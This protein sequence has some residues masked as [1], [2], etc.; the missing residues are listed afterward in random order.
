MAPE[1]VL[2]Q[3]V[4]GRADI[5]AQGAVLY[6]MLAGRRLFGRD[7]TLGT[8]DAVLT[9]EAP[10]LSDMNPAVPAALSDVMRR[11]LMK[12]AADRFADA[13]DLEYAVAAIIADRHPPRPITL[14]SIL[15]RPAP[16]AAAII[17]LAAC[18]LGVWQW[19]Q[20]N[21]RHQWARTVAVP[22]AQRLFDH[23]N[24]AEAFLLAR[25]A[26]AILPDDPQTQQLWLSVSVPQ[27]VVSEPAGADA[28]IAAYGTSTEWHSLGRTPLTGV[29][30][31]R[32]E[33]RMR[34]VKAG[35]EAI[36]VARS[37][38]GLTYRL[39]LP[40]AV[41]PG[42]VRVAGGRDPRRFGHAGDVGEFWIDRFEVTNRQFKTFVDG[43]G[44][45]RRDAGGSRSST[46]MTSGGR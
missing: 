34:L 27:S 13:A 15:S 7:S 21:A 32:G 30:L 11:C 39:D 38:P 35:F 24:Y 36:D 14:R 8:F 26:L 25:E 20:V 12:S 22:D 45:Q 5:F 31:P 19:R 29:R 28:T 23:G 1:Q 33:V 17:V 37:P 44:Y 42:M 9:V 3:V 10:A 18:G 43:G 6:E 40:T 4:D 41:P 16:I 46:S 2:G